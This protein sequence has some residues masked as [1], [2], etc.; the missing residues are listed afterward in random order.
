[1]TSYADLELG[2]HRREGGSYAVEFRFSQPESDADIRLGQGNPVLAQF[3]FEGLRELSSDPSAYGKTLTRGLFADPA[4]GA[5]FAQARSAAQSQDVP[6]RLRLLI[7]PSAAEL[8]SL[9]WETLCDPL[10]GAPLFTGENILFSRYLSS[11]DWRPVRLRP[12][13]DLSALVVIANPS[14]LDRYKLAPIDV[15]GELS[16]AK[17]GLGKIPVTALTASS[18][19]ERATLNNL[20]TR[21]RDGCDIL[22]LVCH[23]TL[24]KDE[25]WVWMEDDEGKAAR[26]AGQDLITR[27]KE[28]AQQPRLIVLASCQSAGSGEEGALAALGPRLAEAGIPAVLAM[29][30]NVTMETV[31]QFMPVFFEQLQRDGQI[32]R[33]LAVARGAVR[34]RPD[35]WM[36]VLFMRLRSG[37]IWYVPGF[38]LDRKG[39]EKWP[40]LLRSIRDGKSTPILGPGLIEF[41]LGS[42]REIARRWAEAYH[43][44]MEPHEREDLPQV[45]QYLAVN[46]DR[47]FPRDELGAY[48]RREIQARFGGDL[49]DDL[50][51]ATASLDQLVEFA[52]ARLWEH[53]PAEPHRILARMPF[54]IYVTTNPDNLLARALAEA[55]KDPQV[56]LCPWNEYA[57]QIG[58]IYDTE[59]DYRPTPERPLVY[60]LYGRLVEPDSL[61]LTEDDYLDYLMGLTSNKD[62]I[63]T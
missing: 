2:L 56:V 31:G 6:L 28:L 12:Q 1:M 43:Y 46:Q 16:R 24:I 54:P 18:S 39:F 63:P 14:D 25:P 47:G 42:S 17:H 34:G 8:H 41:L 40:A 52:G 32:D 29:Q 48:L 36:P 23:G 57:Q 61:V 58:S 59:P 62:L 26:H 55:G 4:V 35:Y 44:P 13:G 9:R 19:G 37:Q 27:L 5:A 3:D 11:L 7:G 30:G 53:N 50:R 15:E 21:L 60:H 51:Q 49:P 10:E 20:T 22:Y 33:A 45:A 38:G